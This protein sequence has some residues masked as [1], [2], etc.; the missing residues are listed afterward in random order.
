[1]FVDVMAPTGCRGYHDVRGSSR[2][3]RR[4][5]KIGPVGYPGRAKPSHFSNDRNLAGLAYRDAS[6][7]G[8]WN[9]GRP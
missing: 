9:K 2:L 1:M 6:R 5:A 4:G 3:G 8:E 7:W